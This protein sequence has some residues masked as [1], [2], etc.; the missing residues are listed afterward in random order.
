MDIASLQI[1]I[2]SRK[3][4]EAKRELDDLTAAAQK[5]EAA[6]DSLSNAAGRSGAAHRSAAGAAREQSR[7]YT[8]IA[9][10]EHQARLAAERHAKA[11][12]EATN[13]ID[14]QQ[15]SLQKLLELIDPLEAKLNRLDDAETRLSK[16]FREGLVDLD[17]YNAALEKINTQRVNVAE[18]QLKHV[19]GGANSA[20]DGLGRLSINSVRAQRDAVSAARAMASGN[21]AQA[22]SSITSL[23]HSSGALTA[24]LGGT[25]AAALSVVAAIGALS[26]AYYKGQQESDG[27]NR[28][29]ILT[30]N[31]AGVTAGQIAG[32]ADRIS[33][34][35]GT[36]AQAAEVLTLLAQTG[37]IT[38]HN[39]EEIGEAAVAMSEATGRSVQD[40]IRE[41]ESLSKDP[42]RGIIALNDQYH[43]LTASVYDQIKALYEQGREQDSVSLAEQTYARELKTRADQI[44]EDVGA[45]ETAWRNVWGAATGAWNAMLNT[46]RPVSTDDLRSRAYEIEG[47]L[48]ELHYQQ[49]SGFNSTPGGAAVGDGGK[50]ARAEIRRLEQELSSVLDAIGKANINEMEAASKAEYQKTQDAIMSLE[51]YKTNLMSEFETNAQ[52]MAREIETLN[53]KRDEAAALGRPFS[54]VEYGAMRSGIENKYADRTRA[55][56]KQLDEGQRLIDQYVQRIGLI[57]KEGE[58]E[59]FYAKGSVGLLSFKSQAQFEYA[60]HLARTIDEMEKAHKDAAAFQALMKDL[61]PEQAKT[62]QYI[63]SVRVLGEAFNAGTIDVEQFNLAM[64]RLAAKSSDSFDLLKNSAELSI[65]G[66]G[67]AFSDMLMTGKTDFESF[68]NSIVSSMVRMMIQAMIVGPL[69]KAMGFS[70]GGLVG[71]TSPTATSFPVDLGGAVAARRLWTGGYTGD[72]GRFEPAGIVHKGEGVLN[73]DEI[74][75]LGG[76]AGFN[77]L[78]RAIRGPGH[79]AGGI[80]GRPMLPS[81][82]GRTTSAGGVNVTVNV[83][84]D[85]SSQVNAPAGWEQFAQE[86]GDFVDAKIREREVRSQRQGGLAWQAKQGAFA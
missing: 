67:D 68:A 17:T 7:E 70:D 61:Y 85:G 55:T 26:F 4:Q 18:R 30:G 81:S 73:Q 72:G 43:F 24:A 74:R 62:D 32:M 49:L 66:L 19:A 51:S 63:E 59:Q 2:D 29:L 54:A 38:A 31:Y 33:D 45:I 34:S 25:T 53:R 86:I 20:A 36:T 42:V 21:W 83:A 41:F 44:V 79:S 69:I 6:T 50:A 78:R 48:S 52:K 58:L 12:E 39:M 60:E 11:A 9:S 28:A 5:T 3:A 76:E 64:E 16:S 40:I 80:G 56:A 22:G 13:S 1:E 57:G 14:D 65:R 71:G 84:R 8:R 46:G 27:Y 15:N 47:R 23:S 10:A 37:R 82:P 77:A 35:V 75:A